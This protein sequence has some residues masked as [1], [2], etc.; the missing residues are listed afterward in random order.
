MRSGL[1]DPA[2][3][4]IV[5][6]VIMLA[7]DLGLSAAMR[8]TKFTEEE[9]VDFLLCRYQKQSY[10]GSLMQKC[11]EL[12]FG[13]PLPVLPPLDCNQQHCNC[14]ITIAIAETLSV[15]VRIDRQPSMKAMECPTPPLPTPTTM[16]LSLLVASA[17]L[18]LTAASSLLA[19]YSSL[20][21]SS[22]S[23][24]QKFGIVHCRWKK[25][26]LGNIA[27]IGT[28]D[29]PH[30]SNTT[31]GH[32]LMALTTVVNTD[33]WSTNKKGNTCMY[34]ACKIVKLWAI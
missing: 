1:V 8:A 28:D 32:K 13:P 19:L 24:K 9:V 18:L 16:S 17:P 7:P 26:H 27:N 4:K 21:F 20:L 29:D 31:A 6:N 2:K 3:R 12:L 10:P 33:V 11:Q 22:S 25:G 14:I 15:N 23:T 5:I 30:P 34:Q